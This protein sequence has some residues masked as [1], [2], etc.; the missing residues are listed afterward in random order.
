ML[1]AQRRSARVCGSRQHMQQNRRRPT[2]CSIYNS[3][4]TTTAS[5]SFGYINTTKQTICFL[6][7][8]R[9]LQ[10]VHKINATGLAV[11]VRP[12]ESTRE[13]LDGFG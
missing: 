3:T 9:S 2:R 11:S 5:L 7:T 12:H 4:L 13:Q 6:V 10:E 1:S 8:T